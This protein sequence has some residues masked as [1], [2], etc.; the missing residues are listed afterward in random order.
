[1]LLG[2]VLLAKSIHM[3]INITLLILVIAFCGVGNLLAITLG[4]IFVQIGSLM[5]GIGFI[6]LYFHYESI[7]ARK[8]NMI[9]TNFLLTTYALAVGFNIVLITYLLGNSTILELANQNPR[10]YFYQSGELSLKIAFTAQFYLIS[11][12]AFTAFI[13]SF[14]VIF[15][16]YSISKSKPAL[17]DSIGLGFLIIYRLLFLPRFFIPEETALLLSTIT[18]GCSVIGL[19]MILINYVINS[20]Y[21]YLLPFP[22]H[23]FMIYN[24][25]GVLCY[26]RKVEQF[27]PEMEEKDYLITGAF[28]AITNLV[29]EN[30]E[31]EAKIQHI[32]AQQYQIFFNPLPNDSGTLVVIAYGE[33]A[34]F[35]RS[36]RRFIKS[37]SSKL[38]E[39]L[40]N[41]VLVSDI[42]HDIDQL[43]QQS[44]PYV[45]FA[46]KKSDQS[47]K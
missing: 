9:I 7:A 24:K 12:V 46:K 35:I 31:G 45:N 1:L 38:L 28:S 39:S 19:L 32:N 18:L 25:H 41:A 30:L 23:S 10:F 3:Q 2:L 37:I 26:S 5:V 20:D 27:Q 4:M 17:V 44:Y 40:N 11:L 14:T 33:T 29:E 42:K 16:A 8:P 43:I 13:R 47:T 36:L 34:L 15:K 6:L 21:L 22:I